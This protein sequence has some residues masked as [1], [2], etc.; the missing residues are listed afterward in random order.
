MLVPE[1]LGFW[2]FDDSPFWVIV[3][4]AVFVAWAAGS[5]RSARACPRCREQNR[6][7]AIYCA[8]CGSKLPQR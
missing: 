4:V 8:Q 2:I 6:E 5:R 7:A 1:W 3:A